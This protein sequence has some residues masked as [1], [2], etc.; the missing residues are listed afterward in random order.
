MGYMNITMGGSDM[1]EAAALGKCTIFGAHAFNFKQT[2]DA[3]LADNGAIMVQDQQELVDV[4]A[5]ANKIVMEYDAADQLVHL[6]ITPT[7]GSAGTHWHIDW[8][9]KG[10]WPVSLPAAMQPYSTLVYASDASDARRVLLGCRDG[11][12]REF[13]ASAADD[14]GTSITSYM[15]LGPFMMASPGRAGIATHFAAVLDED[16]GNVDWEFRTG[17]TGEA[18][19]DSTTAKTSGVWSGGWN[20][21][22][23]ARV[24]DAVGS[25]YVAGKGSAWAIE[26]VN[27][28]LLPAGRVR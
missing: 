19:V 9:L 23:L 25:I 27:M 24:C 21:P 15:Q 5:G 12:I 22:R 14:D 13:D 4:D 2:V 11:Y 20:R 28:K 3:L 1:A 10:M 26:S 6:Y 8:R 17:R 18:A 16:S 7:D